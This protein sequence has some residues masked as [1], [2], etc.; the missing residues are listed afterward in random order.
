MRDDYGS[1]TVEDAASFHA[2]HYDGPRGASAELRERYE[3]AGGDAC[4]RDRYDESDE[5]EEGRA[6]LWITWVKVTAQGVQ[7]T[8]TEAVE[9]DGSIYDRE[10]S[11]YTFS[12]P[13]TPIWRPMERKVLRHAK[14]W[15]E[16]RPKSP[17]A[18]RALTLI[19]LILE[20]TNTTT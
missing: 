9:R 14:W 16:N 7:I 1:R 15:C 18:Q 5:E 11:N 13:T 17:S 8:Y 2:Y 4:N 3:A 12:H 20:A 10:R 19:N 6:I